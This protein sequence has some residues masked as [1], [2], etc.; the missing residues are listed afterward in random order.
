MSERPFA[1]EIGFYD[2]YGSTA[3]TH[4]G[5]VRKYNEDAYTSCPEIGLWAVADGV[6]GHEAGDFASQIVTDILRG[7]PAG[8][9]AAELLAEVYLRLG[10]A[11]QRLQKEA[12]ERGPD[13]IIATTVVVLLLRQDHFA[14]LWAGDSRAYLLRDGQIVQVT[15][16]HSL[17]QELIDANAISPAEAENHPRAN[18]IT[19]AVGSG[20]SLMLDKVSDRVRDG[21]RFLLCSDGLWKMLHDDELAGLLKGNGQV[22][23]EELLAAALERNADDNVT[24]V[25]VEVSPEM[26]PFTGATENGSG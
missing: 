15:R 4:P 1:A 19:R 21:D 6:G 24:V 2:H 5:T 20:D 11:H 18:V 10:N 17:V 3:I 26:T 8:L 22:P 12:A 7:V 14:C 9:S 23:A 16:D 13:T 25:T